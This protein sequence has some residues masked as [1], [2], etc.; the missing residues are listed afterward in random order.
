MSNKTSIFLPG[1]AVYLLALISTSCLLYRYALSPLWLVWGAAT[2]ISFFLLCYYLNQHLSDNESRVFVKKIFWIAL[3]IRAVYATAMVYYYY[4]QNG[5]AFEYDAGD[6]LR[7]H[8]QAAYLANLARHGEISEIFRLLKQSTMGFSDQ[9]YVLYLTFLYSIFG[10]NLLI[11]RLLKALMSAFTCVAIYKLAQRN[12]DEKTAKTAAIMAVLMPQLIHYTGVNLKE[13]EM[14]FLATMALERT[15][16]LFKSKRF[17]FWNIFLPIVLTALT[18]GFRTIVGMLLIGSYLVYVIVDNSN[19]FNKKQK[20]GIAGGIVALIIV[21]ALTPI[22]KEMITIFKVNFR[23][24]HYQVEKYEALGMKYAEYA[25]TKYLLPGCFTLPL[26]NLVDVANNNQKLMNGTYFV[27]N[28]LAFFA[29]WCL[30]IAI[31]KKS[32]RE[33]SL[34]GTYTLAY[35]LLI[36]FSFAANSER[37]HLPAIPGFLIM[38][39][40]AMTHWEKKDRIYFYLYNVLLVIAIVVWN[41]V[42]VEARGL[43]VF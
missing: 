4:Y 14:V 11:P 8:Y 19:R 38:A 39:S 27:K 3:G 32:W 29:M 26:T 35:I 33:F 42:K 41:V 12:T 37:Y 9:G 16:Y 36:A 15:D 23:E 13:T 21:L 5:I 6:S 43:P 34:I 18:F 30:V 17:S 20:W 7:Y 22:G 10:K 1:I 24:S 40:Y 28:Y 31:R 25:Q 2:V